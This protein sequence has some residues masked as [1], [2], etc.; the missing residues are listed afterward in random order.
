MYT[1]KEKVK[2]IICEFR[3]D[4]TSGFMVKGAV[5]DNEFMYVV[6]NTIELLGDE[7]CFHV[8]KTHMAEEKVEGFEI[9]VNI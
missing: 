5:F 4:G 9:I 2:Q 6:R 1:K 3:E 7:W 8:L